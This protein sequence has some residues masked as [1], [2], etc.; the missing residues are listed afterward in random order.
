M[1]PPSQP[2]AGTGHECRTPAAGGVGK[3]CSL[4]S[5]VKDRQDWRGLHTL[6]LWS[7]S[8]QALHRERVRVRGVRQIPQVTDAGTLNLPRMQWRIH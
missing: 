6:R 8:H 7:L 1:H 2:K 4:T 3:E 5:G